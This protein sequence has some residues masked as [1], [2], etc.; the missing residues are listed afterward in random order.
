MGT[1]T[2]DTS[3]GPITFQISGEQPTVSERLKIN[4]VLSQQ[5]PQRQR[6]QRKREAGFDPQF[7]VETGIQDLGLRRALSLAD[8]AE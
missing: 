2:L 4:R 3:A 6:E 1:I 7:D 5:V 8:D